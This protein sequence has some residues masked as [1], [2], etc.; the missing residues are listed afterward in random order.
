MIQPNLGKKMA[1]L[2]KAKGLTQ[3]GLA[4][5]CNVNVRTLQR[6]ESG[7]V[8]PRSYTA[9]VIFAVLEFDLYDSNKNGSFI[10]YWLEHFYWYFLDL[11]N[12]KTHK[13]EKITILSIMFSAI[14]LGL[15]AVR[16]ESK[17]QKENEAYTQDIN[18]NSSTQTTKSG[19]IFSYF[20]CS[21]CFNEKDDM[22]G[23]DVK[24]K[25]NGVTVNMGLIKLNTV[26]REFNT[27]SVKGK[28]FQNKVELSCPEDMIKDDHVKFTA[29]KIEKAEG[30]ILL[31][32][33]ARITSTENDFI[34]TDEIIITIF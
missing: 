2:R 23:R 1:E 27:G 33:N 18:Q 30:K 26:T 6:I 34:E 32:G 17:A 11:F 8:T 24:F 31:K 13:M 9:R 20:S 3:E 16:S 7:E 29:D 19:M 10:F 21:N 22:I 12:L 4:E 15:F 28:L 14:I 25:I 5:K